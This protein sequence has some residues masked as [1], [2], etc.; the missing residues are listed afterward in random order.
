M[1]LNQEGEIFEIPYGI[2]KFSEEK[3]PIEF[4]PSKRL[5]LMMNKPNSEKNHCEL[6][7]KEFSNRLDAG[8]G[9]VF[10]LEH[11]KELQYCGPFGHRHK[12][13]MNRM[14][15]PESLIRFQL[16]RSKL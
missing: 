3:A 12:D 8:R 16:L 15:S 11:T 10:F 6:A 5:K 9:L 4:F 7:W 1:E 2:I 14:Y 13:Q